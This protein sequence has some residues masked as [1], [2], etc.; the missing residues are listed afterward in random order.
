MENVFKH[1]NFVE[2][3]KPSEILNTLD[4]EGSLNK[5]PFMPE[6]IQFCGKRFS[7]KTKVEKTCVVSKGVKAFANQDIVFLENLRCDGSFH[8]GCQARCMIFWNEKWLKTVDKDG[9]ETEVNSEEMNELMTNLKTKGSNNTYFCQSTQ[10]NKATVEISVFERL[11]K[12][13]K[14]IK[15]NSIGKIE[16]LNSIIYPLWWRLRY[17]QLAGNQKRTP[18]Q[19]LNLNPG[20]IV[21][22]KSFDD[23]KATLNK[24]SRNKGLEFHYDMKQYCGKRF[25]VK[26][27]IDRLINEVDGKMLYLKNTVILDEVTCDFAYRF[28]GCSRSIYKYWREV[29]LNRIK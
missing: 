15:S 9:E 28:L 17:K 8:D 5:L 11:F 24:Y 12:L 27:R 29:W 13:W 21:E 2:I 1:E 10:L 23:I 4:S 6:M 25:K 3:K 22:V 16:S 26:N 14:E 20:E 18:D 7:I 19:S